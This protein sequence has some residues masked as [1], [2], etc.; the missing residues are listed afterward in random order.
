MASWA[1]M[2]PNASTPTEKAFS[3]AFWIVLVLVTQLSPLLFLSVRSAISWPGEPFDERQEQLFVRAREL[4]L[5]LS[6]ALAARGRRG[7][8]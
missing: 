8:L 2:A 3:I 4:A 1:I 6:K 5:R 7:Y